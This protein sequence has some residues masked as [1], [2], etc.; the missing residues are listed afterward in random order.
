M[1]FFFWG[2]K[3]RDARSIGHK[4]S[5]Q[6]RYEWYSTPTCFRLVDISPARRKKSRVLIRWLN[7]LGTKCTVKAATGRAVRH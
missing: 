6:E 4:Y 2:G 7:R 3:E 5:T 1:I